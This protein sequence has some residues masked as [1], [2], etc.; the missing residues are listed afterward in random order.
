MRKPFFTAETSVTSN[1]PPAGTGEIGCRERQGTQTEYPPQ[2]TRNIRRYRP[3][4]ACYL[5]IAEI[6]VKIIFFLVLFLKFYYEHFATG[7]DL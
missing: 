2:C 5:T 4:L 3:K 6:P 7:D 1:K